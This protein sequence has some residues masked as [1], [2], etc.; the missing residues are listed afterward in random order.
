[1]F[2]RV[3]CSSCGQTHRTDVLALSFRLP[4]PVLHVWLQRRRCRIT[5]E[6]VILDQTR[7]FI[8]GLL[9][10]PVKPGDRTYFIGVWAELPPEVF[11]R[12]M[13]VWNDDAQAS[14]P[15]MPG[16][17]ANALPF[18]EN[19]LGLR[20]RLQ[21][22]G[23]NTRPDF[24]LVPVEHTLFA[25]Q[26][27]GIDAHRAHEYSSWRHHKPADTLEPPV[28]TPASTGTAA[29]RPAFALS[30]SESR[31]SRRRLKHRS[32]AEPDA[33]GASTT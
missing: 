11:Q 28:S 20:L 24:A 27:L 29:P 31:D 18:H 13:E 17:L 30:G 4:D 12:I 6:T 22:T 2:R 7:Y 14:A 23:P 15:G 1:M 32:A 16:E 21:L 3:V 10:L 9:P 25:E 19:T 26:A 5:S 33:S 8:R